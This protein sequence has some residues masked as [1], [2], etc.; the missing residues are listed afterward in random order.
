MEY[1]VLEILHELGFS[2]IS[3]KPEETLTDLVTKS[4]EKRFGKSTIKSILEEASRINKKSKEEMV[5][6]TEILF[7]AFHQ[8]FG[9]SATEVISKTL[10][11]D[12]SKQG[13]FIPSDRSMDKLLNEISKNQVI[14]FFENLHGN[15]HILYLWNNEKLKKDIFTEFFKTTDTKVFF[16]IE[17]Y[18]LEN[19]DNFTY[20]Q[21]FSDKSKALQKNF[22]I[23][24]KTHLSN[25]TKI[26]TRSASEDCTVWFK[27]GLT[28]DVL[29]FE[30]YLDKYSKSNLIS[31]LCGYNMK[32]FP[33]E[34]ILEEIITCHKY[35]ILAE[36]LIIH[37]RVD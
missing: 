31:G 2:R 11:K 9:A 32:E 19:T 7:K 1:P 23:I 24:R 26:T 21:L 20:E 27:H 8:I 34:K 29:E 30:H 33:N 16:S 15:D 28:E 4:L 12:L 25:K 5:L 3:D 22:D 37:K 18:N 13:I 36:P 14:K 17:P 35:V 10:E 6:N